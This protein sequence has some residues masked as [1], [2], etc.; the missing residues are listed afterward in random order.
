MPLQLVI[1]SKR[2]SSWSLRPWL[3]LKVARIPFKE[4]LV[5]LCQPSTAAALA[6]RS[7]SKK[8]P[9]LVAGELRIWESLAILEYLA[10]RYPAK[11]LWPKG[12]EARAVARAVASEMHAGFG[13]L[14]AN[15]PMDIG[16][17]HPGQGRTPGVE[18]DI[19]RIDALWRD[20]RKRFGK[21][22]PFLFGAFGN[23]DAMFAP[24][25]SRFTTYEVKLSKAA[26]DYCDAIDALPAMQAW[27]EAASHE[28]EVAE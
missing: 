4:V 9:V 10:D 21:G 5:P 28:P 7:P 1:G 2:Y 6:R 26:Q 18:A 15:M 14:R 11:G 20:C 3:A 23:A 8:V 17:H 16:K 24:V 19:A 13:Q 12:R 22:G 27:A 25:V